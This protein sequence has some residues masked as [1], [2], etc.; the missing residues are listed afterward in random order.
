MKPCLAIVIPAY[1]N[2]FFRETLLSLSRQTN[3]NFNVYIGDDASPQNLIT[4]VE[5][6]KDTLSLV[7]KRFEKNL[8]AKDLVSHWERCIALSKEEE[9]IWLFS[10]DDL[11]AEDCVELF[12]HTLETTN[13]ETLLHFN[14]E[15]IDKKGQSYM[16]CL[17]FPSTMSAVDFFEKKIKGSIRSF[18]VE[19]IFKKELYLKEKGF[20]HFDL[21]WCTDDATWIK[22]SSIG[23]ISTIVEEPKIKWRYSGENI[24]SVNTDVTILKRKMKTKNEF[25][26]WATCFFAEQKVEIS[27]SSIAKIKWLLL[28]IRESSLSLIEKI[29]LAL[30]TLVRAT[31]IYYA[32]IGVLYILYYQ[33]LYISQAIKKDPVQ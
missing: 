6:F 30:P 2:T 18:V 5:E 7:Y 14:V 13:H 20:Q 21:A 1:K 25:L 29:N 24:S 15:V 26:S 16:S 12:Y 10:D 19:Y 31:N 9:W 4:I 8:G 32:P 22:Y 23:G 11:M 27:I 3:K 33:L 17:P 28:D